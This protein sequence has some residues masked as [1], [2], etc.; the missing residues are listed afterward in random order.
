MNVDYI[1][2][3]RS[4]IN[5]IPDDEH[6]AILVKTIINLSKLFRYKTVAEGVET[7]EQVEYLRQLGLMNYKG[8][9]F[10]NLSLLKI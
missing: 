6:S 1:K 4:F 7:K 2:I 10:L 9:I 3:D 8:T 5:G